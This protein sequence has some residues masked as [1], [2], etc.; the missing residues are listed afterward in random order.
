MSESAL[1]ADALQ[2]VTVVL[3]THNSLHCLVYLEPLI[4]T[5]PNVIVVDNASHDG[6]AAWV[7]QH[8]PHATLLELSSNLGFG[9]ANNKAI[10]LAQTEWIFLLNPDCVLEDQTLHRL[11]EW[12]DIFPDAAAIA[13]QLVD[14]RGRAQL[15]YRWPSIAWNSHGGGAE[16]P[17][18][19]GFA[20]AAALLLRR[21]ALP[22]PVF[23]ER[24][25][26]YYEDDDLCLRLFE[27]RRAIV[28]VPDCIAQHRSRGS[29]RTPHPWRSQFL[30][31]FHHAQSKLTFTEKH[32]SPNQA[33]RKRWKLLCITALAL[34]V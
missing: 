18:C 19:V 9:A 1:G 21:C 11:L 14:A 32:L 23:D 6:T 28:V 33:R 22:S 31:S 20:C 25:F 17:A 34:P 2:R 4:R 24:F 12:G 16:G 13:P 7:R 15:N 8:W 30:R 5:C 10:A 27:Q 26:L 29:V 3:V